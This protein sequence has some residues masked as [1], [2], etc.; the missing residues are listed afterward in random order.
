MN[1]QSD[2]NVRTMGS[3]KMIGKDLL[4]GIVAGAGERQR[5]M[6]L[7]AGVWY[8]YISNAKVTS[9]G[10]WIDNVPL[11][12]NGTFTLPVYARAGAIIPKMHVDEQTKTVD[13]MRAD[14]ITHSELIARV[15]P[16]TA[17]SSFTLAEDDGTS[18]DYQGGAV[19]TTQLS[20]TSN[21]DQTI[22]TIA[23]SNG[24]Y[25]DAPTS[26]TNIVE[27]V[28]D[29]QASAVA[30]NDTVLTEHPTKEA[31]DAAVSGWYNAGNNLI[32]AKSDSM[33]VAATKT[34][35]FTTG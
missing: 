9:T 25:A 29:T 4:V 8:D 5:N 32:I 23:A 26:R 24:T 35:T 3:E 33:D 19:R 16:S 31:F 21:G 15:Y 28:S 27:L 11:W 34:F 1:Y 6:Y 7:P 20:Q 22:V 30:L 12:R 17:P 13:G 2:P 14:G 18:T 10:E